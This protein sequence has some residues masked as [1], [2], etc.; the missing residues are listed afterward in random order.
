MLKLD[1]TTW[2]NVIE[3]PAAVGEFKSNAE[4]KEQ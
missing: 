2:T 3:R 1:L 4:E